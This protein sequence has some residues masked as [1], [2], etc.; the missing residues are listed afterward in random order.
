VH[1]ILHGGAWG[2]TAAPGLFASAYVNFGMLGVLILF[3]AC[4]IT[5]NTL[6][7]RLVTSAYV[8]DKVFGIYLTVSFV[9]AL[10][11][12]ITSI[13]LPPLLIYLLRFSISMGQSMTQLDR[14]VVT[15][16]NPQLR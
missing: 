9:I 10:S 6:Y 16:Q 7:K 11:A 4:F 12:D 5:Y 8:E 15:W 13:I 3:F 2:F 1:Y 14:S